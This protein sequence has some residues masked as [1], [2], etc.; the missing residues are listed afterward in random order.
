MMAAVETAV[1]D[2]WH[3][4]HY[5]YAHGI[6][7]FLPLKVADLDDPSTLE[8]NEFDYYRNVLTFGRLTHWDE[9]IAAYL[10]VP[11]RRRRGRFVCIARK[12]AN[13]TGC[14]N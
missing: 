3:V 5:A 8:W 2:E 6:S 7:I 13:P 14:Y 10:G 4:N 1:L 11:A 9:F 12:P